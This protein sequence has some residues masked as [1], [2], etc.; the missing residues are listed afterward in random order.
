MPILNL[1]LSAASETVPE[2]YYLLAVY[3]YK[4]DKKE[5]SQFPYVAVTFKVQEG[6]YAGARIRDVLSLNPT[7]AFKM[8]NFL[9]AADLYDDDLPANRQ[10]LDTD[11]LPGIKVYALIKDETYQ[12]NEQSKPQRYY[13]KDSDPEELEAQAKEKALKSP[14][15]GRRSAREEAEDEYLNRPSASAGDPL[16]HNE[17]N[18]SAPPSRRRR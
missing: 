16:S 7:A 9:K 6:D 1:D 18:E 3:E 2:G 10:R 12:G 8:A 17:E 5:G 15:P 13:S 14:G 4:M 11:D